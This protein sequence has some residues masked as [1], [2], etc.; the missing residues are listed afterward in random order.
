MSERGFAVAGV[1]FGA[2][3]VGAVGVVG[4]VAG[5]DVDVGAT[6]RGVGEE[7]LH[8]VHASSWQLHPP[9]PWPYWLH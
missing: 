5:C 4:V 9:A 1:V 7:S 3:V 2:D 8:G 6:V